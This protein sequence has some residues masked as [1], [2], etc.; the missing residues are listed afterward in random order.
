MDVYIYIMKKIRSYGSAV[1]MVVAAMVI[2]LPLLA[3]LQYT[4]LGQ[5][6]EQEYERMKDNL[7]T[8]AFHCSLDF[9]REITDLMKSIGE[10]L[11]GSNNNLQKIMH[12]RIS[13]WKTTSTYPAL[14]SVET[15]IVSSPPLEQTSMVMG[16]EGLTFLLYKD[17]SAIAIPIQDRP[18]QVVLTF[19]NREYISSTILPKIIQSNFSSSIRSE[20]DVVIIDDRGTL[21]YSSLDTGTNNVLQKSDLVI[22]FLIF[23]PAPRSP[24][25]SDGPIHDRRHPDREKSPE[26]FER[27]FQYPE[28]GQDFS[29]PPENMRPR[30]RRGRLREQGLFEIRLKHHEGS[31]EVAINNNRLRNL[32]ISFGVLVLLGASMVFLLLS[33]MRARRLAQQQLEFVAGISH[34]L[35]TPLAVLKSAGENLADGVIQEK[36]R[37]R[38]YGEL[39]KNE[40]IRLSEMVEKALTYSGIQSGKQQYEL[41]RLDIAP[42]ITEAILNA[43]KILPS[44]DFMVDTDIDLNLPQV[45]GDETALQSALENLII[46]GIKYSLEKKWIKIEAH[47]AKSSNASFVKID[48]EDCGFGIALEDISRIFEP[49]YRGRNA[50]EGQIQGSGLGLNITKYIIESHGGTISVKSSL[51][52]GSTFTILLP[53][54]MP[55][56]EN[57]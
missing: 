42:I 54:I 36:D 10:P 53:S 50:I 8:T 9:S 51:K 11:A 31:L 30:E 35:R 17:L 22:P 33:T 26:P 29:P 38:K 24:L 21:L 6:S 47:Q 40:V 2:I 43:K 13:K 28:P 48:I 3:Y 34:E 52:S 18:H 15:K 16:D 12:E 20:Y 37:T 1:I 41:H 25:F 27:N 4:W 7:Q 46:N 45:L 32:V 49:F 44:F 19:L 5:I 14:V 57:T 23:P 55:E 56:R 39:I